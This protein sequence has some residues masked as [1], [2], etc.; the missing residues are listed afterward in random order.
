MTSAPRRPAFAAVPVL[1]I[2]AALVLVL[3]LLAERYGFHR[4]ELYFVVAGRHPALGYPDQPPITPLLAAA[5]VELLGPSPLGPRIVAALAMGTVVVLAALIARELGHGRGPQVLAALV[6]AISGGA[7]LAG[8]LLATASIDVL[9]W[10]LV[11][12]LVVRVLG[13]ADPR[14]WLVVGAVAGVGLL[15]KHLVVLLGASLAVGLLLSRRDVFRTPWP[16]LAVGVAVLI[17]LP[18]LAWQAM[19]DW[20]QLEMSGVIAG[21]ADENRAMLLP[22]QVLL[23]GLTVPLF[24]VGLIRLLVGA[25]LRAWRAVG[26][27]YL[28]LLALLVVT[29]GKGY[30]AIGYFAVL[31]AAGSGPVLAWISRA[32]WRAVAAGAI[33]AASAVFM[34]VLTLPVLPADSDALASIGEINAE[35]LEQIGWPELVAQIEAIVDGLP[36]GEREQAVIVTANY[37]EAGALVVLGEGRGLPPVYSGHQGFHDWGPPPDGA[38]PVI[39]VGMGIGEVGGLGA[40]EQ[41]ARID[42]GIGVSNQEQGAPILV[43]DGPSGSW[44]SIWE[45]YRHLD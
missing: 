5:A 16:W 27:G 43:C 10:T 38:G 13:G 36:A 6:V 18:N 19:N 42:N 8:H 17:W 4:D 22:M 26:L 15:N 14:L 33:A 31:A 34:A 24:V 45:M 32:R 7:L 37:G 12:W 41:V 9:F 11:L 21:E 23:T 40:C 1:A 30:Y 35:Q 25:E 3:V 2:A 28:A 29:G 39:V 20:P 44:A